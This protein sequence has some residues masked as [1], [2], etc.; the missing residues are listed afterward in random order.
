MELTRWDEIV[1]ASGDRAKA[2]AIIHGERERRL[3][4]LEVT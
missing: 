2:T 3:A 1:A 4:E